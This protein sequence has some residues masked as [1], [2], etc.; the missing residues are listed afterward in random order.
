MQNL[1]YTHNIICI[2][3]SYLISN[4]FDRQ[5]IALSVIMLSLKVIVNSQNKIVNMLL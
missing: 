1:L 3:R 4:Y 2:F 5:V